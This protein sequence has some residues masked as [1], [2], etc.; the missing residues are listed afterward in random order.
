MT[1]AQLNKMTHVKGKT[2][3]IYQDPFTKEK[4]EGEAVL[5]RPIHIDPEFEEWEV[6]FVGDSSNVDRTILPNDP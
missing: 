5:V 4:L 6:R 2:V 1:K 3:K